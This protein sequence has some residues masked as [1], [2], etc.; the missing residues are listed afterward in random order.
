M[1]TLNSSLTIRPI[2]SWMLVVVATC[3]FIAS[4]LS[5][6]AGVFALLFA[7]IA[8][9]TWK[10][11]EEGFLLLLILMP[12]LPML[13]ITQTI[14]T[15]TLVKDVIILTL[16]F[17]LFALPLLLRRLPYRRN[18]LFAPIF[19][20]CAWAILA[21]LRAQSLVFGVVL[22]RDIVLYILAYF[23]VLYLPKHDAKTMKNRLY[24]F[25]ASVIATIFLAGWQWF[26]A[27]DS[28][29][30]RF[31]PVRRIWIPR[32]SGVLA[33]PSIYGEYLIAAATLFIGV[34]FST[35]KRGIQITTVVSTLVLLPVIFLTYSRGVWLGLAAAISVMGAVYV[36][37]I[38]KSKASIRKVGS[39]S[40]V[41]IALAVVGVLIVARTTPAGGLLRSI[42]D[43]TY[44]SNEE[45]V[46]FLVR[47]IAPLSNTQALIGVGLGNVIQ[48]NFRDVSLGAIDI[49]SGASRTVQL[50]KNSTLVDNQHLKTFIE[51]GIVGLALYIWLYA[52]LA[53]H[54]V[55]AAFSQS[56]ATQT[57][58]FMSIGFLTAFVLQGFLIDVWDI[59]PTNL[60]F[61]IFAALVSQ[62]AVLED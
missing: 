4:F 2:F 61:W 62:S 32:L 28:A 49:A 50:A 7:A 41:I 20:L 3:A 22:L 43:P 25:S 56:V 18:I 23:A 38:L 47:L 33:H 48:Q 40:F 58:G 16:F 27:Q 21:A 44:G 34:F 55:R 24:W 6:Q 31:D 9:Y 10:Y 35:K 1:K 29:V 45:R 19:V 52:R 30:L 53:L 57:I 39:Y 36:F 15:F 60:L 51:M 17:R 12:L 46:T 59:F 14:G 5:L 8:W 13:K 54:A 42:V 26:F 11:P 37:K